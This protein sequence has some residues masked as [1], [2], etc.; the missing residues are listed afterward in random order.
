MQVREKL[1]AREYKDFVGF[2]KALKTKAMKIS[3]VL[4]SIIG[5]FSGPDRLHLR[6]GYVL[7]SLWMIFYF[8]IIIFLAGLFGFISGDRW[9]TS[10]AIW[11]SAKVA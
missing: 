5:I 7:L 10:T 3:Q 6:T 2:M 9:Q 4:Q 11:F 1:S 8:I